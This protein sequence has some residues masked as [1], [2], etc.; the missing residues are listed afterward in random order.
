MAACSALAVVSLAA[1]GLADVRRSPK[2]TGPCS[3]Y[4]LV[5]AESGDRKSTVDRLVGQAVKD[6]QDRQLELSK[7]TLATHAA[8]RAA[9]EAQREATVSRMNGDAKN[10]KPIEGHQADL[11]ALENGKPMPPRIPRLI[12]TDVTQEKLMRSLANDWPSAGVFSSEGAAVFGG[13]S[14]G[15][16]SI[17]RTLGAFNTLWDGGTCY[18]DRVQAASFV[19]QGARM[20]IALQVQP[21][22]LA[23]FLER[24]R[25]LSRGTGF[26]ARFLI[27]QPISMQG[28]RLYRETAATPELDAFS[29]RIT[30]LLERMPRMEPE[31]GLTPELLDLSPEAKETWISYYNTIEQQLVTSGD[32][33]S[34]PDVAAK[35]ADNIARMA[36]A[37]HVFQHGPTGLIGADSVNGAGRVVLWHLYNARGLLTPL[38]ASKEDAAA[39]ALDRWLVDRCRIDGSN[40]FYT[41][42]IMQYGPN[43]V[44]RKEQLEKALDLL[45]ECGRVREAVQGKRQRRIIVNPALL[46]DLADPAVE[47]PQLGAPATAAGL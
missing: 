25:G 10:N 45:K 16:D 8:D 21:H 28:R 6:Y 36:A 23:D 1:Q 47:T 5:V 12:Y 37:L 9:W 32:F 40:G 7:G 24:D 39:A 43:A 17:V 27:A 44:R 20:T 3:L 2:L 38:S 33:A 11:A 13:H 31:R 26:M 22:V 42:E 4:F 15:K 14:M 34:V 18:V 46:S 41:T 19:V 30:E 35:A 29:A